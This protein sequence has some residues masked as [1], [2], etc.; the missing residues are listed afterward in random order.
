[1]LD[2]VPTSPDLVNWTTRGVTNTIVPFSAPFSQRRRVGGGSG[3]VG[4]Q[5]LCY[6][7]WQESA[8][9]AAA[10]DA[11]QRVV[12]QRQREFSRSTS[13]RSGGSDPIHADL[14][15][16][17]FAFHSPSPMRP[18]TQFPAETAGTARPQEPQIKCCPRLPSGNLAQFESKNSPRALA[19]PIID[20]R[21]AQILSLRVGQKLEAGQRHSPSSHH[22]GPSGGGTNRGRHGEFI[23]SPP[24]KHQTTGKDL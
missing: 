7:C 23:M 5:P 22:S 18:I 11:E 14:G 8:G 4:M 9:V 19:N 17:F 24:S 20:G 16:D 12:R 2:R 21:T 6:S 10:G 13:S 3:E 1:M 15:G